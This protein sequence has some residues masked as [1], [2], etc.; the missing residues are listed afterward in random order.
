[1]TQEYLVGELSLQLAQLEAAAD[2]TAVGRVARLRRE[3]EATL[4]SALGPAVARAIRLADELCWDSVH[5]GDVS[6]FDGHAAWAAELHEFA[7]CAGLL[8]REVRR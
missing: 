4:P 1:M 2:P 7:A 6:A 3:V 8:D 5:R